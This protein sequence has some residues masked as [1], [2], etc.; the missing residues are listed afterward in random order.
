MVL[1]AGRSKI[2]V[3]GVLKAT[4]MSLLLGPLS[5]QTRKYMHAYMYRYTYVNISH[6]YLDP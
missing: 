3:L 1:E 2:C 6:T 4:G 5:E